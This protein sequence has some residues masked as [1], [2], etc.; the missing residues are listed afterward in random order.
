MPRRHKFRHQ[1]NNGFATAGRILE[2]AAEA[3]ALIIR[4]RDR[5][6]PLDWLALGAYGAGVGH[7]IWSE[8]AARKTPCSFFA[9]NTDG[10]EPEWEAAAP[11]L[12]QW[13]LRHA[14]DVRPLPARADDHEIVVEASL[15]AEVIGWIEGSGQ[16]GVLRGPYYRRARREETITA[17]GERIWR[18]LG[19]EH[20]AVR[21]GGLVRQPET[22]PMLSTESLHKLEARVQQFRARGA[23]RSVLLVGP[24]GTGKTTAARQLADRLGSRSVQIDVGALTQMLRET[25][26]FNREGNGDPCLNLQTI[27]DCLQPQAVLLDDID[28]VGFGAEMLGMLEQIRLRVPLV[29]ATANGYG[30][31]NSAVLRPGR[32][33]EMVRVFTPCRELVEQMV[34]S[35]DPH[36]DAL[37]AWPIAWVSEYVARR[38]TLGPGCAKEEFRE[39]EERLSEFSANE[40]LDSLAVRAEGVKSNRSS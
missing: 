40:Q 39:L 5:P 9:F 23:S 28:R 19:H 35:D 18:S 38:D 14:H 31:L 24:P 7:K 34:G 36:L 17:L 13:I 2:I 32:F 8:A 15:D 12:A 3:A 30:S 21:G 1:P 33:D 4:L 26:R 20:L 25:A 22:P 6:R 27:V 10:P 16:Q 29:I 37:A 11:V